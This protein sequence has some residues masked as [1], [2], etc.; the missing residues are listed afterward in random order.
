MWNLVNFRQH[1]ARVLHNVLEIKAEGT[2]A[3]A[4]L[5]WVSERNGSKNLRGK[6]VNAKMVLKVGTYTYPKFVSP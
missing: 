3:C 6:R 4:I 2:A 5:L 1:R